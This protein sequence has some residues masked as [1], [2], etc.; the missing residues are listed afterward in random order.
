MARTSLRVVAALAFTTAFAAA[1]ALAADDTY[2]INVIIPLTGG[3]AF[4]GKAEQQALDLA[5]GVIN[6]DGGIHGKKLRPVYQDD[7]SQPQVAVQLTTTVI[8]AHPAVILGSTVSQLCNAQAPLVKDAGPVMWCFSPSV[9][10]EPGGYEFTS[11]IDSHDQQRALMTYFK[12]KGWKRIALITTTDASGQDAEKSITD[13]IKDPAFKDVTLVANEHFAPGDLSVSAQI[14]KIRSGNPDAIVSWATTAAGG[15]V[16][17][18]LKQAGMDL[19]TAASGSNMTVQQMTDYTAF[20]P[21]KVYFGVGEWAANGD[22]RLTVPKEVAEQQK[23]FFATMKT[24]N[25]YPDSGADLG[26]EPV[27]VIADAL[28][29]L[30]AGA[31][32]KTLHDFLINWQGHIGAEG[33]YDFKKTPQRGLNID[34][35]IVVSWDAKAKEWHPVS[36]LT[37]TPIE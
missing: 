14:E 6:K 35:A 20:L 24:V 13:L 2:D 34:N 22:P 19:P 26:W 32:A 28:N 21:S 9:R 36:N 16:F 29:K 27:R 1:P 11:Q 15:T 17:R 5:A 23:L 7:Q 30:P 8:A 18:A 3:G 25:V 31:D 37:G 33:V 10:T 12:G 4:L